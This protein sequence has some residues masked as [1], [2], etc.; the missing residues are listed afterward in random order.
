MRE[1][2]VVAELAKSFDPAVNTES[3][4]DFRYKTPT[5]I[6]RSMFG[7]LS[8]QWLW[9]L[10]CMVNLLGCQPPTPI[11]SDSKTSSGPNGAAQASTLIV[12]PTLSETQ[13]G[14]ITGAPAVRPLIVISISPESRVKAAAQNVSRELVQQKWSE[15]PIVIDNAAGITAPLQ[16]ASQQTLVGHDD[17]ARERWL[18]LELLPAGPLS[19]QPQEQRTLRIWSRDAGLRSAILQFDAG[20]GTQDLGFRSDVLLT[21]NV[22]PLE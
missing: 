11:V 14:V 19:G 13:S 12:D 15:F 18:Q 2:T 6:L 1:N 7:Y 3:L 20:Q 5:L 8:R 4:G 17:A 21:F 16:V 22:R 9:L 10:F